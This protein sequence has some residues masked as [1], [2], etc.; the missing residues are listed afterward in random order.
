MKN[1][2]TLLITLFIFSGYFLNKVKAQE[3]FID[4]LYNSSSRTIR[5]YTT[6]DNKLSDIEIMNELFP[7]AYL[8]EIQVWRTLLSDPNL[9]FG[10]PLVYPIREIETPIQ[11]VVNQEIIEK[12]IITKEKNRNIQ[13]NNVTLYRKKRIL[14]NTTMLRV[15]WRDIWRVKGSLKCK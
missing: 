1:K 14:F 5:V 3:Y 7:N 9:K 4:T 13:N 11:Q 10:K 6:E 15:W 2:I 8:T 12:P